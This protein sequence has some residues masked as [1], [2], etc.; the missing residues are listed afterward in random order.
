[1][2]QMW[3]TTPAT[4]R[5]RL[6]QGKWK[7]ARHLL[8]ISSKVA[9]AIYNGLELGIPSVLVITV[10]PRHGK[11]ELISVS[12]PVWIVDWW[13]RAKIILNSYG[14]ELAEGFSRKARDII[15]ENQDQLRVRLKRDGSADWETTQEGGMNAVGVGGT[16][17]G[18]GAHVLITDD[19]LKN[20]E[21]AASKTIKDKSFDWAMSTAFTRLEPGGV[22]IILATRWAVDDIIGRLIAEG[23]L[24]VEVINFPA[25]AEENDPLGRQVG[26]ALWPERYN[27]EALQRI[28]QAIG[29]YFYNALYQQRPSPADGDAIKREWWRYYQQRPASFHQNIVSVDAAFKKTVSG[30][31]VAIQAW[32]RV[33]ADKYLTDQVRRRMSFT[34]TCAALLGVLERQK[35]WGYIVD[36][37][38]VED[39]ANGPA[40]I[41]TLQHKVPG[42]IPYTPQG[43]KDAR[44]MAH[45]AQIEGGNIYLPHKDIAPWVDAYVNEWCYVGAPRGAADHMDQVDSSS[46]AWAYMGNL[47]FDVQ[48]LI[49][50]IIVGPNLES[51]Q[52]ADY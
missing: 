7:P 11:S 6:S 31:Y 26:E 27:L 47:G 3:R 10:P 42:V 43:S 17:T 33:D 15:K 35:L 30:S 32:G 34:D 28:K 29:S 19:Y 20:A 4:M 52:R 37:V 48:S 2:N 51:T 23:A 21:E 22:W 40:I 36:A 8:Y 13:P 5:M 24:N 38:L 14:A 1:M 46:Q 9:Q 49:D 50:S 44:A 18:R 12:T 25:E 16:I 39:A 45:S 41:S